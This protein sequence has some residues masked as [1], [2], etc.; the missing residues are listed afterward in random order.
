MMSLIFVILAFA[1]SFVVALVP[2]GARPTRPEF[3][4]MPLLYG[5]PLILLAWPVYVRLLARA[6]IRPLLKPVWGATLFPIPAIL[7]PAVHWALDGELV[8]NPIRFYDGIYLAFLIWYILFG[9][10]LGALFAIAQ[11]RTNRSSPAQFV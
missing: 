3:W 11:L 10:S 9:V 7:L 5:M 1:V 2:F 4:L 6:G 8:V